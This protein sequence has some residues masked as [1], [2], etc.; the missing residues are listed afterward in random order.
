MWAAGTKEAVVCA[1][2]ESGCAALLG[3]EV[4]NFEVTILM[5]FGHQQESALC[6]DCHS[7]EGCFGALC[8]VGYVEQ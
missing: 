3:T 4:D 8:G 5:T 1:I 7:H 2:V 6:V